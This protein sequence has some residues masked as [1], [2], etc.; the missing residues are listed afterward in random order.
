MLCYC[1]YKGIVEP[2]STGQGAKDYL[3]RTVNPTLLQ[4][5][6]ELSKMKPQEPIVSSHWCLFCKRDSDSVA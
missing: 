2:V 1:S 5:L 3:S 4:G 6:T